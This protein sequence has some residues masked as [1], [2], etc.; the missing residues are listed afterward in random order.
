MTSITLSICTFCNSCPCLCTRWQNKMYSFI[1]FIGRT[2]LVTA[3]YWKDIIILLWKH[4]TCRTFCYRPVGT[5]DFICWYTGLH[6]L[7]HRTISVGTQDFIC[8]YTGLYPLVHRTLSVGTHNYI[9]WYTGLYLLV[10]RTT[11]HRIDEYT[12]Y[13]GFQ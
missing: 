13:L 3:G 8:W 9:C 11:S 6:L 4:C 5:Q 2:S 12:K 10:H 7:I 1:Y